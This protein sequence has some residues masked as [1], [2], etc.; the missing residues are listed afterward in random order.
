M[1]QSPR[2]ASKN[3]SKFLESKKTSAEEFS[4]A[5]RELT[6][7]VWR[8]YRPDIAL[9]ESVYLPQVIEAKKRTSGRM[10]EAI[11]DRAKLLKK[12]IQGLPTRERPVSTA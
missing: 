9:V 5:T 12:Y 8:G 1:F 4:Y 6:V 3:L 10:Q 7:A 2:L 11:K